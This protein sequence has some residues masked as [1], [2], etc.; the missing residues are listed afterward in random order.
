MVHAVGGVRPDAEPAGDAR[1]ARRRSGRARR[2]WSPAP[3]S[4]R[5]TGCRCCCCRATRSRR[6]SPDPSCSSSSTRCG[7][8]VTVNDAFRPVS[9]FFDRINR[10]EQAAGGAARRDAR[11][12]RP[13]RDRRGRRSRCPQD[14]QAEAFDW[15]AELFEERVWHVPRPAPDAAALARAAELLR[16]AR[17]PLIVAGGGVIYSEATD[18][19]RGLVEA[20][21]IPVG[22]TQAG[23][24]SLPY[25]HPARARRDRRHR[26]R[27]PRTRSAATPTSSS[28]SGRAGAT[29]RRRRGRCPPPTASGSS[30]STS[31]RSTR[32]STPASPS[33][34]TRGR[35]SR[36]LAAALEGWAVDDGYRARG[37]AP[38]P[39]L[40]RDRRARLH[41]AATARCRPSPR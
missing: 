39:R 35:R 8:D 17:R 18:A 1:R 29:S 11:P 9:R 32:R 4:R 36:R 25:D 3:R 27:R 13:G 10:P 14:V 40:G 6:A 26:A 30:T 2:T 34:P 19:L 23:K 24:G 31:P 41:A 12:D 22:E 28:G 16:S 7:P 21:G 5:S 38:G 20:T 33:S 37:G 15:P